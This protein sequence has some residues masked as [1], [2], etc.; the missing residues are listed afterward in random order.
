VSTGIHLLCVGISR[1]AH[2]LLTTPAVSALRVF[3]TFRGLGSAAGRPLPIKSARLVVTPSEVEEQLVERLLPEQAALFVASKSG[4]TRAELTHVLNDWFR[5]ARS[6]PGDAV[7][8]YF[9]GHGLGLTENAGEE[10]K[11]L[12]LTSDYSEVYQRPPKAV[13]LEHLLS[14]LRPAQASDPIARRQLLLLDCCRS[15]DWFGP[16][17]EQGDLEIL[18]ADRLRLEPG[19]RDD[20]LV[21]VQYAC[22]G[23]DVARTGDND[24]SSNR[25][26]TTN[27]ADALIASLESLAALPELGV[28][29]LLRQV[30]AAL[31]Q[32][33]AQATRRGRFDDFALRSA[34]DPSP[35]ATATPGVQIRAAGLR[36]DSR[37]PT[38]LEDLGSGATLHDLA[39]PERPLGPKDPRQ[40]VSPSPS[41][42][43]SARKAPT[44]RARLTWL[45]V[46]AAG[47]GI[48][49]WAI[50]MPASE[51]SG[52]PAAS[53][54]VPPAATVTA[55]DR[56]APTPA[57]ASSGAGIDTM[58]RLAGAVFT[59]GSSLEEAQRAHRECVDYGTAHGF[60]ADHLPA[61]LPC[62]KAF[63]ASMYARETRISSEPRRIKAFYLDR[64]EV[65]NRA[66]GAWLTERKGDVVVLDADPKQTPWVALRG[67]EPLASLSTPNA[68]RAALKL[69][70]RDGGF[71]SESRDAERP[72]TAVTWLGASRFCEAH[73]KRLPTELEWE[74]AARGGA[75]RELPWGTTRPECASVTFGRLASGECSSAS[76]EPSPVGSSVLDRTPE[77][78]LDLAG[79]VSEWTADTY[80]APPQEAPCKKSPAGV[81][82]VVKGGGFADRAVLLRS[83]LRGR[84]D[85]STSAPNV[86][87]RCA[88][89]AP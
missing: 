85:G 9:S 64:A 29:V 22:C 60:A 82:R 76:A 65:T 88:K 21:A 32:R 80:D 33:H 5:E 39:R 35:L 26:V 17:A 61:D 59:P 14:G 48:A 53:A 10:S 68:P 67:E 89:D 45:V 86:G 71:T 15:N 55:Q 43:P 69:T 83:A 3:G 23:G 34:G 2:N 28:E 81:C 74:Y 19:V 44:S 52:V 24:P 46:A 70:W 58:V 79:N 16:P 51:G 42:E 27:Y 13:T 54:S 36:A 66:F 7:V 50:G 40:A 25:V 1:Y 12:L 4:G 11:T 73:G 38:L 77:G 30:A 20:R 72:V 57:G 62:S 18:A 47:A 78:L 63:D 49:A 8:F 84:L 56:A 37:A 87:F 31:E 41:T 6:D 75:R